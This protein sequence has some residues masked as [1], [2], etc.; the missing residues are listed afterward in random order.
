[1]IV[2]TIIKAVKPFRLVS[3]VFTYVLGGGLVQYVKQMRDWSGFVQGGVFLLLVA[4]SLDLFVLLHALTN[5]SHWFEDMS[6]K[7]VKAIRLATAIMAAT[8]LTVST[9]IFI[10]WMTSGF[11]SQGLGFLIVTLIGL[12]LLYYFS[13]INNSLRPF[14]IIFEA[15]IFVVIPPAVAYFIQSEDMHRFLNLVVMGLVPVYLAYR[16]LIQLKRFGSDQQNENLTIA[17][18]IGW[19]HAMTLHNAL[20]LFAYLMLALIAILGFPW[21]LLWPVFLTLPIGLLEI[22]LMERVRHGK[23][24]L[25]RVMQFA[26]A[27]IFLIPIYLLGFA[28][29]IR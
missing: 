28:F 12:G 25:W 23:K 5:Q 9:T 10:H 22:W 19:Q 21:F 26:T 18:Q 8:F 3:L 20:I 6:L 14:Q 17:T 15:G 16:L 2:K 11:L 24:P 27:S 13:Q 7:M 4:L 29:W 1:M